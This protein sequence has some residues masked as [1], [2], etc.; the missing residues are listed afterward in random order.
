MYLYDEEGPHD[1]SSPDDPNPDPTAALGRCKFS[2]NPGVWPYVKRCDLDA[3]QVVFSPGDDE[4]LPFCDD[5]AA[6][7]REYS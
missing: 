1:Q 4:R 5:H 2:W 6:V 7:V 3:T